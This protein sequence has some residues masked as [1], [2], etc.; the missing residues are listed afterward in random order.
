MG[1]VFVEGI[2][3]FDWLYRLSFTAS[4]QDMEAPIVARMWRFPLAGLSA[5]VNSWLE[6]ADKGPSELYFYRLLRLQSRYLET[7][8]SNGRADHFD[9]MV[10]GFSSQ[11]RVIPASGESVSQREALVDLRDWL[12]QLHRVVVMAVLGL[13][14]TRH[15]TGALS[16]QLEPYLAVGRRLH[17]ELEP[18]SRD[19]EV[20]LDSREYIGQEWLQWETEGVVDFETVSV[21]PEDYLLA[22]FALRGVE[23]VTDDQPTIR[24]GRWAGWVSRQIERSL[25][26]WLVYARPPESDLL[27]REDELLRKAAL[28]RRGLGSAVVASERDEEREIATRPIDE[29]RKHEFVADLYAARIEAAT[30]EV[31]F[32]EAGSLR[33]VV[34][35]S[36]VAPEKRGIG[37]RL[38]FKA[39]FTSTPG[40]MP[41][42][43]RDFGTP[44]GE[45]VGQRLLE[46][47]ADAPESALRAAATD[48]ASLIPA[49]R[50]SAAELG[51]NAVVLLV[52]DWGDLLIA[53]TV[54]R[55]AGW[56]DR[57]LLKESPPS[58][59]LR[60]TLD[61]KW[62]VQIDSETPEICVVDPASWGCLVRA[63]AGDNGEQL[64]VLVRE[65]DEPRAR[66]L[67]QRNP[68]LFAEK[69]NED[70]RILALRNRVEL[71]IWQRVDFVVKDPTRARRIRLTSDLEPPSGRRRTRRKKQ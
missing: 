32:D 30:I 14:L 27:S 51:G 29:G 21:Q 33:Y 42:N 20:G 70:E 13:A 15:R 34:S 16:V 61:G 18:L 46:K 48:P 58:L 17:S 12:L 64:E 52:G 19:L 63:D 5:L 4:D 11:V 56:Q 57:W 62:V 53:L 36:A 44:L 66:E 69:G 45:D 1:E 68:D 43:A 65:I 2:V 7:A 8:L 67:L 31:I 38:P 6:A 28:L 35:N 41:Y 71:E 26:S 60:G 10:R 23:L 49:I 37:P 3:G 55:I 24:L 9:Q 54:E 47:L 22:F 39:P 59:F 25:D 40:W 50:A